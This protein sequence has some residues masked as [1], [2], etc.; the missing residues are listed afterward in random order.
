MSE[1]TFATAGGVERDFEFTVENESVKAGAA[2]FFEVVREVTEK[3]TQDGAHPIEVKAWVL[4]GP[5]AGT[6]E[7]SLWVF[8]KGMRDKIGNKT[9]GARA[10]GRLEIYKSRGQDRVGLTSCTT[11][12][13]AL[14]KAKNEELKAGGSAP[15]GGGA[16]TKD[17]PPF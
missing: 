2:V 10:A 17:S 6:Y 7:D 3:D 11:E 1:L 13:M 5:Q 15:A 8:P 12:Q 16:A 4:D 9:P 14:A